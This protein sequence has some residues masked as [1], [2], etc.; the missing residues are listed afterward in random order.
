MSA[1]CLTVD[2]EAGVA[3][4]G[5]QGCADELAANLRAYGV[6]FI[7]TLHFGRIGIRFRNALN[8]AALGVLKDAAAEVVDL[9]TVRRGITER[10]ERRFFTSLVIVQSCQKIDK[11]ESVQGKELSDWIRSPRKVFSDNGNP[12]GM[13]AAV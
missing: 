11:D 7:P 10:D 6:E 9:M 8:D 5:Y 1:N 3:W 13:G 4:I 2:R 12:Y